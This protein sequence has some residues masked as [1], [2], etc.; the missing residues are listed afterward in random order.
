MSG[1]R[2]VCGLGY[3]RYAQSVKAMQVVVLRRR[4]EAS[5]GFRVTVQ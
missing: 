2:T 5:I 3:Y 4:E 1:E